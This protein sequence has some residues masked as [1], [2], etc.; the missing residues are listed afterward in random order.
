MSAK[1]P[2]LIFIAI[3]AI[4]SASIYVISRSAKPDHE[5]PAAELGTLPAWHDGNQWVYRTSGGDNYTYTVSRERDWDGTPCYLLIGTI[6]PP[7]ERWGGNTWGC[8]KK[9]TLDPLVINVHGDNEYP[10]KTWT[11]TY[12][13]SADPWPLSI[14]KTYTKSSTEVISYTFEDD[15]N[16]DEPSFRTLTITVDSIEKI[17]VPAGTFESFKITAR[18]ND[19]LAETRWYSN[20][21]KNEVKRINHKTG[22]V[23]ELISYSV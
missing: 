19:V 9:G 8:Y 6:S 22:E 1:K 12:T 13:Y 5:V 18:E 4:A 15:G 14:G 16:A 10:V 23:F 17:T 11:R 20:I 2:L 3:V 7:L 21:V